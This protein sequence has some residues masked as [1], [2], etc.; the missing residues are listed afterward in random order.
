[1][2][3][4]AKVVQSIIEESGNLIKNKDKVKLKKAEDLLTK[5]KKKIKVNKQDVNVT[6]D[7]QTESVVDIDKNA[8]KVKKPDVSA[9]DAQDILLK[10][11]SQKLT[12]K[13][14]SDFNV[15]SMKSEKDILKFIELIS[16]KYSGDIKNRTRGIQ[17]HKQTKALQVLLVKTQN[18]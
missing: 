15:K 8:F 13:V 17:D 12:T 14:L 3:S 16:K 11:N 2:V 1:M 6:K 18:I 5:D 4:S 7:G 10:Y 9:I